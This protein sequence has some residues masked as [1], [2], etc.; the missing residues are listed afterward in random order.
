MKPVGRLTVRREPDGCIWI[1]SDKMPGAE[2]IAI[3]EHILY[4]EQ[5]IREAVES[6]KCHVTPLDEYER[7]WNAALD[8]LLAEL[9]EGE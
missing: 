3:G 5:Q 6:K 7:I 1:G 2:G 4:T 9:L 8:A